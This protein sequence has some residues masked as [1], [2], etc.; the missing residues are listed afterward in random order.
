MYYVTCFKKTV[1]LI[2]TTIVGGVIIYLKHQNAKNGHAV[3]EIQKFSNPL[4]NKVVAPLLDQSEFFVAEEGLNDNND[5]QLPQFDYDKSSILNNDYENV[6]ENPEEISLHPDFPGAK[7]DV[8]SDEAEGEN[9]EDLINEKKSHDPNRRKINQVYFE[10]NKLNINE[11]GTVVLDNTMLKAYTT[12][13]VCVPPQYHIHLLVNN[14]QNG[15]FAFVNVPEIAITDF[16]Q[17]QV[18]NLVI[19]F[20]HPGNEQR[21]SYNVKAACRDILNNDLIPTAY[22]PAQITFT[23]VND[24][25]VL[26][27]NKFPIQEG[28][29][30]FFD[31]TN[32]G[33]TDPD[34]P[35]DYLDFIME[36]IEHVNFFRVN[37]TQINSTQI[38]TN[39]F[40]Q[41]W[42]KNGTMYLEHNGSQSPPS[43]TITVSDGKTNS[44][45]NA[46]ILYEPINDAPVFSKKP[47]TI[48]QG[49]TVILD[50]TKLDLI[51]PDDDDTSI[52]FIVNET[53]H[54]HVLNIDDNIKIYVFTREEL[55]NEKIALKHDN[56]KFAPIWKL[57]GSD[58]KANTDIEEIPFNY[59]NV[60]HVPVQE[61]NQLTIGKG[62]T[63]TLSNN[64][65]TRFT[66]SD[67]D[68]AALRV[69]T[70]NTEHLRFIDTILDQEVINFIQRK[71][72]NGE[73][74]AIHDSSNNEPSYEMRACDPEGLCSNW[75]P[76]SITFQNTNSGGTTNN[77]AIAAGVSIVIFIT[78]IGCIVVVTSCV[79]TTYYLI[80]KNK[81]FKDLRISM[82]E[83]ELT[84]TGT[85]NLQETFA[86]HFLGQF[87]IPRNEIELKKF[88]QAGVQGTVFK[89]FW[90]KR[91]MFV[92]YKSFEL[93]NE[94][95]MESFAKEASLMFNLT[96]PNLVRIF[97]V[98][99]DKKF[100]IIMEYVPGGS[101]HDL[102]HKTETPLSEHTKVNL[103]YD[104]AI[105]LQYL[106]ERDIMHRDLK[107]P[108]VLIYSEKKKELH[109]KIADFG[110]SREIT[111]GQT[112]TCGIGTFEYMAPELH[113]DVYG[114]YEKP[115]DIFSF[116]IIAWEMFTGERPYAKNQ[117]NKPINLMAIPASIMMNKEVS[118]KIPATCKHKKIIK[119]CW[120]VENLEARP[121]A[122]ELV[123]Y[124]FAHKTSGRP[125]EEP[126]QPKTMDVMKR[127]KRVRNTITM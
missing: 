39:T 38:P 123:T 62:E 75:N 83:L 111:K 42:V 63:V 26:T 87:N 52:K 6:D 72:T 58:G 12:S 109:A 4:D 73:I 43:F 91:N 94:E 105:G 64:N 70:Q 112:K 107:P 69:E 125:P 113:T 60:N 99:I 56:S 95:Q 127:V 100:A 51:D 57:K 101:L 22:E 121:T 120:N 119:D 86:N 44:T 118:L 36:N 13:P 59:T 98:C 33:A 102:L 71:I 92:A 40:P 104:I 117:N 29:K 77:G 32:L 88:I 81:K 31:S 124:F 23:N 35:D 93:H 21:P 16:S 106:H 1:L 20:K 8:W 37:D 50:T 41:W 74:Q 122:K 96:H 17:S 67:N 116:G 110:L 66:D 2:G 85:S 114:T 79:V 115:A 34:D 18:D 3:N 82:Q 46:N 15:L 108:N 9:E 78:A 90:K 126:T 55:K 89:A 103:L 76:A 24:A 80:R 48:K 19:Q 47:I 30:L 7:S 97:G 11:G 28:G 5:I 84:S 10:N 25:P 45:Y 53:Q 65:T 61:K 27:K 68:D 54:V 49:Q 14:V